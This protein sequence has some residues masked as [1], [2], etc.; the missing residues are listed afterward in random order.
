MKLTLIEQGLINVYESDIGTK[1]VIAREL[2]EGLEV[3][4]KFT[5]W[6]KKRIEDCDF[7]ENED[8]S[9]V[10]EKKETCTGAVVLREYYLKIDAAKEVAMMERNDKGK[11][12]RRYLIEVEKKYKQLAVDTQNLSPELKLLINM[13]M[14]QKKIKNQIESAKKE[15][16]AVREELKDMKDTI[17]INPKADWRQ[18]TNQIIAKICR[19]MNDYKT[20]KDKVYSALEER[21]RC[22][23]TMRLNNLKARA[24]SNGM[25]PS[26]VKKLNALDVIANDT[27]LKEIYIAIVKEFAIKYRI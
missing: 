4:S 15:T 9:H 13:E 2:H 21:G 27:R 20:P 24:L 3:K 10:S 14:E 5:D 1:V 18:K 19:A 12:Y 8:Y 23:L 7:I 17:V 22:N 16:A 6:I 25:A 26:K 11:Q